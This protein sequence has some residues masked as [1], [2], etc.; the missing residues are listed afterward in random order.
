MN[1]VAYIDDG[2]HYLGSA[3][4]PGTLYALDARTGQ[5]LWTTAT[6]TAEPTIANGEVYVYP[7]NGNLSALDARSGRK[8]WSHPAT[9]FDDNPVRS[10]PEPILESGIVYMRT[11]QGNHDTLYALNATSGS[12]QWSYQLSD[13]FSTLPTVAQGIVYAPLVGPLKAIQPPGGPP[14]FAW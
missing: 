13:I 8:L 3:T 4:S 7:G 6:I 1:G 10:E 11:T 9:P 12:T 5:R 14:G 2:G